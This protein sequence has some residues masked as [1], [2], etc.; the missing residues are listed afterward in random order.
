[1]TEVALDIATPHAPSVIRLLLEKL[2]VPYAEVPKPAPA[3]RIAG[4]GH[5]AR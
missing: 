4:A 3:C 2:G 1:M 5:P